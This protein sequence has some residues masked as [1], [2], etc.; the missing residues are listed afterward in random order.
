[1]VQLYIISQS[2][3]DRSY[4]SDNVILNRSIVMELCSASLAACFL[5]DG[6]EKKYRGDLPGARDG[7]IQM[8]SGLQYLHSK[9]IVHGNLKPENVLLSKETKV[10]FKLSDAEQCQNRP[11][12]WMAPEAL[13][14][15]ELKSEQ[16]SVL[17][18]RS[19]APKRNLG[20]ASDVWSLGCL[21]F[22]FLENGRNPLDEKSCLKTLNDIATGRDIQLTDQLIE[23]KNIF[24]SI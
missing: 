10:T 18:I 13:K 19:T 11:S 16:Y 4:W 24:S 8:L 9:N 12:L 7:L 20:F 2:T 5:P 6:H 1:M 22:Y 21:Y 17:D 15:I 23:G 3:P 14:E